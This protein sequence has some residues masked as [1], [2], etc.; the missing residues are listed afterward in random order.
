MVLY[1]EI[2]SKLY[3]M[4]YVSSK[5]M[6]KS[7]QYIKEPVANEYMLSGHVLFFQLSLINK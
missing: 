5:I 2:H 4:N 7:Y 3:L 6:D 1:N